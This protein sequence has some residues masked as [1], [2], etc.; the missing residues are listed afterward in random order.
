MF[1]TSCF[2][3]ALFKYPNGYV[4]IYFQGMESSGFQR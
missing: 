3:R 4:L 2:D 1:G